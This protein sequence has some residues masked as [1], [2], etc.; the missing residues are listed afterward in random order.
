MTPWTVVCQAPLSMWFSRQEYWSGLPF[1]SPGD[2]PDPGIKLASPAL[3][4]RF[5]ITEPGFFCPSTPTPMPTVKITKKLEIGS[6][7]ETHIRYSSTKLF[8]SSTTVP[9]D[10]SLENFYRRKQKLTYYCSRKFKE[11]LGRTDKVT[12]KVTSTIFF[13]EGQKQ[14]DIQFCL[15]Q[16]NLKI[17]VILTLFLIYTFMCKWLIFTEQQ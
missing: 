3:A 2:L 12:F 17:I 9:H 1:P 5:F 6:L 7:K 13:K 4:S 14:N 8:H 16:S 15:G 10:N 11:I